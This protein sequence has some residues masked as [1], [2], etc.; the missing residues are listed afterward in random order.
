LLGIQPQ[1]Q[2]KPKPL[3]PNTATPTKKNKQT[4]AAA[5]A[6]AARPRA[7][8]LLALLGLFLAATPTPTS[9]A[10][11]KTISFPKKPGIRLLNASQVDALVTKPVPEPVPRNQTAVEKKAALFREVRLSLRFSLFSLPRSPPALPVRSHPHLLPLNTARPPARRR[12][13]HAV[14]CPERGGGHPGQ[15]AVRPGEILKRKKH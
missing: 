14:L 4:Q 8:A 9:A 3:S 2:G 1:Q 13:A 5:A 12:P 7:V 15:H 10:P 11:F 6:R